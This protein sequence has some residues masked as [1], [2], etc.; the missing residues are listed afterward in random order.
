MFFAISTM[1]YCGDNRRV[2]EHGNFEPHTN[3][4]TGAPCPP[5]ETI[6]PCNHDCY[7]AVPR[8]IGSEKSST[9]K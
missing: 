5:P 1:C 6:K 2:D 7:A 8:S 4:K 9:E 3:P